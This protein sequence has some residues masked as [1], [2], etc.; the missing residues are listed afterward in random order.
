MPD[1]PDKWRNT[2]SH[3]LAHVQMQHLPALTFQG[4]ADLK[5]L[6]A[7]VDACQQAAF[8]QPVAER[9]FTHRE[10]LLPCHLLDDL[11]AYRWIQKEITSCY[12]TDAGS[13]RNPTPSGWFPP[14][15]PDLA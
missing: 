11:V 12:P 7:G 10:A 2:S 15:A 8:P 1:K 14:P 13:L 6:S 4:A 5:H 3:Q 9:L